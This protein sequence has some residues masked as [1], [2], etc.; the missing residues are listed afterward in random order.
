MSGQAA[1]TGSPVRHRQRAN[2]IENWRL[3]PAARTVEAAISL[4][5]F[6]GQECV[7]RFLVVADSGNNRVMI[8]R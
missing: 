1:N 8:W 3:S 2:S 5:A 7:E 4:R 6:P